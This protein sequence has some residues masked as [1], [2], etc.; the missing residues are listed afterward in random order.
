MERR[1]VVLRLMELQRGVVEGS[2]DRA[3]LLSG[4]ERLYGDLG[5]EAH[6]LRGA[7][8]SGVQLALPGEQGAEM[9]KD[10]MRR[11]ATAAAELRLRAERM[12]RYWIVR[13]NRD[14]KR[15]EVSDDR[16]RCVAKVLKSKTDREAMQAIANVADDDWRQGEN[17]RG[18]RFDGIEHIFGR[19]IERFE[20][21]RD[22]GD[23]PVDVAVEI[24]EEIGRRPKRSKAELQAELSAAIDR[25]TRAHAG[26]DRDAFNRWAAEERRLRR[27]VEQDT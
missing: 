8:P 10:S 25:K 14:P 6:G 15:T 9:M 19:G 27:E 5:G 7:L 24:N 1:D 12:V 2:L 22:S 26:G 11:K 20:E 17:D 21:L 16:V 3:A 13:T 18:K 4:L 23:A